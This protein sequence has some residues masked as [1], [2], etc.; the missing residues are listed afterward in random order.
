[1]QLERLRHWPL[2]PLLSMSLSA[3]LALWL[4]WQPE[5]LSELPMPA[6]LPLVLLGAW[7]LGAG[8]THGMGLPLH[9]R[10]ARR[11]L[12]EPARWWLLGIFGL[13]VVWR[14]FFS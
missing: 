10:W 1:M 13:V 3:G 9:G 12:G 6:R 8:F 7:A 4:L 5:L 11:L 14:A 2:M